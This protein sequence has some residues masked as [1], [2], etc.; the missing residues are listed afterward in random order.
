MKGK[1]Y[2]RL[3]EW[4][5]VDECYI[6][7]IP[8]LSSRKLCHGDSPVD[9]MKEL[10]EVEELL[11][12]GMDNP[13]LPVG[14]AVVVKKR[15]NDWSANNR[16]AKLR[17]VLNLT[18]RAFAAEIGAAESTLKKWESGERVPSGSAAKLLEILEEHPEL[19]SK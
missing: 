12:E 14:I 1:G 11:L 7:S 6:G 10:D 5:D 19:I 2:A 8:E 16:V 9:V 13:P 18:Q 15:G 4:S 17:K 3:V